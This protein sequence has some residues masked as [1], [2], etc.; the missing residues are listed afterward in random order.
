MQRDN[1]LYMTDTIDVASFLADF[2]VVYKFSSLE[3][4]E[5]AGILITLLITYSSDAN[6]DNK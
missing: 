5:C 1:I 4:M 6:L 3:Y 2:Y